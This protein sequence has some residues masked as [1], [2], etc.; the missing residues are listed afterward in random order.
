[1][2]NPNRQY[3]ALTGAELKTVIVKEVERAIDRAGINS[4]GVTYPLASWS[5]N[6]RIVQQ[7]STGTLKA[8]VQEREVAIEQ[9]EA[10]A[11]AAANADPEIK[12]ARAEAEKTPA[13]TDVLP[14]EPV[15]S[16]LE[17]ISEA[18]LDALTKPQESSSQKITR[19]LRGGSKRFR[20]QPPSPT[21]VREQ[22]N[23]PMP[24]A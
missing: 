23:L 11:V 13:E 4:I 8:D 14:T 17:T 2:A 5:W 22:E 15:S 12:K 18:E 9:T 6:L 7:D 19:A 1:M 20:N 24:E 10:E 3:N 16:D 21:E